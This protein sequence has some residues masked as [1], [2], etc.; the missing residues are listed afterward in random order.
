MGRLKLALVPMLGRRVSRSAARSIRC[1]G[2]KSGCA[3]EHG[4]CA[5]LRAIDPRAPDRAG[6]TIPAH[7]S[8]FPRSTRAAGPDQDSRAVK[9]FSRSRQSARP[10]GVIPAIAD[11]KRNRR[12]DPGF[13][14]QVR[15][16][17]R[18]SWYGPLRPRAERNDCGPVR[19][20]GHRR[21]VERPAWK[22]GCHFLFSFLEIA[23]V[24]RDSSV[25]Q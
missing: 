10:A 3:A 2:E 24:Q 4:G 6:K 15:P 20:A 1:F 23:L 18:K 5:D 7:S 16:A 21:A 25:R 19:A 11:R 22:S 13:Q 9:T 12:A 14:R 17:I 8:F